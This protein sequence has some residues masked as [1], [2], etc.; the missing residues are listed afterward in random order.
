MLPKAK[1]RFGADLIP[2]LIRDPVIL[3]L[4]ALHQS[5]LKNDELAI[6]IQACPGIIAGVCARHVQLM[7]T[8]ISPGFS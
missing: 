4:S 3:S 1:V 5:S 2:V 8:H 6:N 7:S